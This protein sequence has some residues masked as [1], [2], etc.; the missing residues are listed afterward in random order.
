LASVYSKIEK[1][2]IRG[3]GTRGVC[4]LILGSLWSILGVAF[5][6]NPMERF[7]RPG[8]G[9]VLDLLDDGPGVYIF[10]SMW[11]VGG[12][13]AIAVAAQRPITCKD[14]LGFNGVAMPPFLWGSGYWWSFFINSFSDGQYGRP[15]SYI[16][17][18]LYWD[19]TILIVFLSRHLS[20]HPEGP[21]ARR[22][23]MS[24]EVS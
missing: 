3:F 24:G 2:L 17:G 13:T 18:L 4:L 22:R 19:I 9:G 5:V 23:V 8:P 1:R 20:D 11:I 16:A 6:T 21:C 15:G 12:V 10:G 14:D 7:S